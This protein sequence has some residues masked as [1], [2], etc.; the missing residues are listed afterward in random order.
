MQRILTGD[1]PTGKLHLGHFVGTLENRVKLQNEYETYIIIADLHAFTTKA[2]K[3][4]EIR[5]AV[6]DVALDNLAVGI[7]PKIANIFVES[8]IPEIYELASIFSMLI[9]HNKALRN[10]TIKDEIVQK[11]LGENY[12]LGFINYPLYQV[13]DIL[14]VGADLV[15]VGADQLPHVEVTRD[16]AQKFNQL[17]GDTLVVPKPLVGR[18]A[19]LVGTDGNPKMGKS[20]DNCIYL[21]DDSKTV[22]EKVSKTYTDPSRI[23]ASDPGKVEGNPV[24]IYH[25]AFNPNKEEVTELK[26]RYQKG[27]VGDVE[28]KQK[29]AKAL[30]AFLDPMRERRSYFENHKDEVEEILRAGTTKT[31]AEAQKTL[32]AVRSAI[33]LNY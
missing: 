4:Q 2:D 12:S 3:P 14:C 1:T 32:E 33:K 20:L 15:P 7:D 16:I 28:V 8:Q 27:T 9:S 11:G 18:V 24:F 23:H 30:N 29:L 17:Y 22:E 10:P 13:A 31:R 5:D 25:E 21:S 19:K 6:M 26:E